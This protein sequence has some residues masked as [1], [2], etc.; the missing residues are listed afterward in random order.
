MY[1]ERT[2]T[3]CKEPL[4]NLLFFYSSPNLWEI[5]CFITDLECTVFDV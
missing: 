3:M 1:L 5:I 2:D 4:K